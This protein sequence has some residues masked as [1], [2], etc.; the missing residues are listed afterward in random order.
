MSGLETLA[1]ERAP[2]L[3]TLAQERAPGLETLAQERA[4]GLETLA[5]E[6]APASRRRVDLT[7]TASAAPRP[8]PALSKPLSDE[9]PVHRRAVM[10]VRHSAPAAG[11]CHPG[12]RPPLTRS[13]LWS[14]PRRRASAPETES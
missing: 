4:P 10:A 12:R 1:Q 11:R 3:E 5:P 2:G 8:V 9:R 7:L 6:R 14:R 13:G